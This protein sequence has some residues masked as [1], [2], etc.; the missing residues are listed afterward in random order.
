MI[1]YIFVGHFQHEGAFIRFE[2]VADTKPVW[3]KPV[4]SRP[5][6]PVLLKDLLAKRGVMDLAIPD[7]W[8]L[9]IHDGGYLVC[10]RHTRSA[11]AIDFLK[12]LAMLT[13]CDIADYSSLTFVAPEDLKLGRVL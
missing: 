11:D 3:Y 2:K 7:F 9:H 1:H 13:E 8:R 12:E 5:I 10:D 6:D 4:V